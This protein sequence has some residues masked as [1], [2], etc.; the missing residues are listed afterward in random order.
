MKVPLPAVI[1]DFHANLD[2]AL[3]Q[4]LLGPFDFL[5]REGELPEHVQQLVRNGCPE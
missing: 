2:Q 1:R 4:P 5:A 3:D